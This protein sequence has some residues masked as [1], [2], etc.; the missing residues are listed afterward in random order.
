MTLRLPWCC[1]EILLL[2]FFFLL[3]PLEV[4]HWVYDKK[5][6]QLWLICGHCCLYT[7]L[8]VHCSLIFL[9]K[10]LCTS[11]WVCS[12]LYAWLFTVPRCIRLWVY[13]GNCPIHTVVC[14][15]AF[16]WMTAS[17]LFNRNIVLCKCKPCIYLWETVRMEPCSIEYGLHTRM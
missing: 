10:P 13:G 1:E 5:A 3:A 9:C 8:W 16:L 7:S 2:L 6:D 15:G 17:E 4:W 14:L 11:Y 12:L